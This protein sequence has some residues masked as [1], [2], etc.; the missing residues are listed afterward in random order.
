MQ[1]PQKV[2]HHLGGFL[3]WY[4]QFS[5]KTFKCFLIRPGFWTLVDW[6][7]TPEASGQPDTSI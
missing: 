6:A 2:Y 5:F 7:S 1:S 4:D 3:Y